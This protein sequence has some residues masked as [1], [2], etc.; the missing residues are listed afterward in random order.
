VALAAAIAAGKAY[1][2]IHTTSFGGGEI[3]GFLTPIPEPSSL[4][5]LGLGAAGMLARISRRTKNL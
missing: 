2:N 5:L 1:W 3:R 4:A